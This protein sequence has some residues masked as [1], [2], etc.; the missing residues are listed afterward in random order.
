MSHKFGH[1]IQGLPNHFS[2]SDHRS[3]QLAKFF[4]EII[5][6]SLK[7]YEKRSECIPNSL[8]QPIEEINQQLLNC[9]HN[10]RKSQHFWRNF[11]VEEMKS[12]KP[13]GKSSKF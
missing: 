2:S 4:C 3:I 13:T 7:L 9:L 5:T 1:T 11:K 8:C 6:E 12:K 10:C